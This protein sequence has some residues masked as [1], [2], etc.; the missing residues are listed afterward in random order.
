M[1]NTIILMSKKASRS[2]VRWKT[3]CCVRSQPRRVG[4]RADAHSCM[5][6]KIS[7]AGRHGYE[8]GVRQEEERREGVLV[9]TAHYNK[10]ADNIDVQT[11]INRI[12]FWW[13]LYF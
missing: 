9:V 7:G 13:L 2:C 1:K 8:G 3:R 11:A 4:L 5:M 6:H 10:I 12:I